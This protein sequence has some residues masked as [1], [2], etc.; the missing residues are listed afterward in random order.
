MADLFTDTNDGWLRSGIVRFFEAL[1]PLMVP[2]DSVQPHP[3]N[4][5]N[6]DEDVVRESILVNGMYRPVQF[7]QS[8]G[9]VL[10][11]NTTW[12]VVKSLDALCIPV[13]GLPVNDIEALRIL[14]VDNASAA[15]AKIDE[16]LTLEI[17]QKIRDYEGSLEGTGVT[18]AQLAIMEHQAEV[19]LEFDVDPY[20]GWPTLSAQVAPETFRAFMEMTEDAEDDG[21][22]GRL[23]YLMKMT[24]WV[25]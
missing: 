25:G 22:R 4:N 10:A 24:G 14:H 21:N 3:G 9:Y 23:E 16:G 8:T 17:L 2:I 6:G 13:V 5:N 15:Q 18:D 12:N 11:G 20:E 7:Q 1:R 19:P